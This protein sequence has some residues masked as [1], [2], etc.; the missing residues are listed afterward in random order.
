M[1]S[2]NKPIIILIIVLMSIFL[3]CCVCVLAGSALFIARTAGSP[4]SSVPLPQ[5]PFTPANTPT[6]LPNTANPDTNAEFVQIEKEV[7]TL[8]GLSLKTPL[9]RESLTTTQLKEQVNTE[10]FKDYT[11]EKAAED[12]TTLSLLGL[13]PEKFDILG[14]YKQL[15]A[16]QIA[17]YY[18]NETKS[19]YV[20]A[21]QGFGGMERSTYAHEFTH[22]LQDATYNFKTGLGYSDAACEKNSEYCAAIQ[23]L[24]E[25]DATYTQMAWIS[26]YATKKD[27]QDLQSFFATY[28]SPILDSAPAYMQD[29]MD[30]PYSQGNNF[31]KAILASGGDKART[32]AFTN[33]KPVST[34]QILHPSRY[35]DNKP[36][37]VS[38]PELA[39][40][41]GGTWKEIDRETIGEWYTWL[42]LARS[43][44]ADYRQLESLVSTA[45]EGWGGDQY[46]V[47]T[48]GKDSAFVVT[49]K[50]DTLKDS[51]EAYQAFLTYTQMRF[52]TQDAADIAC[53][54]GYC[55]SL[56]QNPD[57]GLTWIVSTSME[58]VSTLQSSA[59]N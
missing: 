33:Q 39:M 37:S 36:L 17:G 29:D 23:A 31:V 12:V 16:E 24:I 35:P 3:C 32:A 48:D 59:R 28:K 57:Q 25:G 9:K 8:R 19:M 18:D 1:N 42:I 15:Y 43:N 11:P 51:D 46:A 27:M 13:L 21:D 4:S 50:W 44:N 58:A 45:T 10:F 5:L 40:D 2:Q 7:S 14:F 41:L 22:A 30:F 6:A 56:M 38:L 55:S 26:Q 34:E 52:G 54:E 20:V 53:K 49:Y 47:L